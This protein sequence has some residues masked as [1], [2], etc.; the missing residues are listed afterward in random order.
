MRT[1][2]MPP[3]KHST[4]VG[5]T[6]VVLPGSATQ[7]PISKPVPVPRSWHR[8]SEKLRLWAPIWWC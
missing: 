4:G 1:A 2:V 8:L 5:P 3:T 6:T 7:V